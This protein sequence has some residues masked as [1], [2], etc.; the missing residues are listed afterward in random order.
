V[1]PRPL[2]RQRHIAANSAAGDRIVGP[3]IV[4]NST[5]AP[6]TKSQVSRHL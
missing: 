4:S 6:F 5:L 3:A 2:A 1:L